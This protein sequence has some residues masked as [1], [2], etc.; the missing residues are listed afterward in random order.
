MPKPNTHTERPDLHAAGFGIR[1]VAY[2]IDILPVTILTTAL[3]YFFAGFDQTVKAYFNLTSD[4]AVARA[5][6]RQQTNLIRDLAFLI[7]VLYASLLEG[8]SM[9]RT[10]GK[11]LPGLA[12]IRSNSQPLTF[13]RSFGRNIA[14]I[15]SYIPFGMGFLWVLFSK[16]KEAWHD[17]LS[18]TIVTR[19]KSSGA[20]GRS[21]R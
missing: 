2:L 20:N 4:N 17:R 9:R 1:L 12:V 14:K 5:A 15:V 11:R 16:N 18:G 10:I 7:Y 19:E 8:S 6:F 13:R 21:K 3:F